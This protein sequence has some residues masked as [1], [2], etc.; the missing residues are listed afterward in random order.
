M[1]AGRRRIGQHTVVLWVKGTLYRQRGAGISTPL[2]R[3]PSHYPC[4]VGTTLRARRA[5]LSP[6]PSR[7]I[8]ALYSYSEY[9]P[10]VRAREQS[11]RNSCSTRSSI[12]S[13]MLLFFFFSPRHDLSS[14]R[15]HHF[16]SPFRVFDD[17]DHLHWKTDTICRQYARTNFDSLLL[18]LL[19]VLFC[20]ICLFEN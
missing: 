18:L 2:G 4:S 8:P 1:L 10:R 12:V 13:K 7:H 14:S 15:F 20:L 9:R 3:G 19:L 5:P 17:G 11:G 6:S 16:D